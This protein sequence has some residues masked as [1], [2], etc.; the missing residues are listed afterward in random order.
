MTRTLDVLRYF[1]AFHMATDDKKLLYRVVAAIAGRLDE[2]E[3]KALEVLK[4]H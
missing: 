4:S 3:Q 1:P 2:L